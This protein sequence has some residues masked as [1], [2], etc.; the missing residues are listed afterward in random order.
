MIR[1]L[2]G[3]TRQPAAATQ[4]ARSMSTKYVKPLKRYRNEDCDLYRRG[5]Q[6]RYA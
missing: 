6:K 5:E 2:V 1:P 4:Q 3:L